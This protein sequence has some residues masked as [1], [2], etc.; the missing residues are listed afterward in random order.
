VDVTATAMA[1]SQ[2]Q[3]QSGLAMGVLKK[4]LDIDAEQG[5]ELVK[6]LDQSSGIGQKVDL[7]A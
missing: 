2:Y 1:M 5:A 4:A 7:Y 3:L 6:M